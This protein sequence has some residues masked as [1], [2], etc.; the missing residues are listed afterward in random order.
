MFCL[1]FAISFLLAGF[2]PLKLARINGNVG[3]AHMAYEQSATP[4][5]TQ[6]HTPRGHFSVW[7]DILVCDKIYVCFLFLS[8][9]ILTPANLLIN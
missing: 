1:L 2:Y 4:R 7:P 3:P 5:H 9:Y 8:A 6:K